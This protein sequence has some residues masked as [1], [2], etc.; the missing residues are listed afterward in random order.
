[1]AT[2]INC[3]ELKKK[4]LMQKAIIICDLPKT[5]EKVVRFFQEKGS[6]AEIRTCNKNR[7]MKLYIGNEI[8]WHCNL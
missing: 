8:Q 3:C 4:K 7:E 5:E 1:M 6:L 2:A